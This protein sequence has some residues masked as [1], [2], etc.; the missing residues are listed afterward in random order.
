M[1][2]PDAE[3]LD[4]ASAILDTKVTVLRGLRNGAG[5]ALAEPDAVAEAD[6]Y[7]AL[8]TVEEMA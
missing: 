6:R 4:W 7:F 2:A 5:H 8:P 1:A 3:V